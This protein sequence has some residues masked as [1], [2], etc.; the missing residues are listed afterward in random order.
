MSR[1]AVSSGIGPIDHELTFDRELVGV[2]F[3]RWSIAR[4]VMPA[5]SYASRLMN[6]IAWPAGISCGMFGLSFDLVVGR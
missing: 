1:N 4:R 5:R 6:N 2:R 3:S